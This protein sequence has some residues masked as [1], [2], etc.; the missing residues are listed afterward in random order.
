MAIVLNFF[1]NQGYTI[2]SQLTRIHLKNEYHIERKLKL[3]KDQVYQT[4]RS[5]K[6]MERFTS[7]IDLWT[8][9]LGNIQ[10][11][12]YLEKSKLKFSETGIEK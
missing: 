6:L 4:Q 11:D 3:S 9:P 10:H 2:N 7:F 5:G 8:S 1:L 12:L